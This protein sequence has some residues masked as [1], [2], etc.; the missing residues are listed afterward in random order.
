MDVNRAEV[1]R[2]LE[3]YKRMFFKDQLN[4]PQ[5]N[6]ILNKRKETL[7]LENIDLTNL[8][9]EI[10]EEFFE[11]MNFLKNEVDEEYNL[12]DKN[13]TL[14]YFKTL[15]LV[16]E[17]IDL[18]IEKLKKGFE[19]E[20]EKDHLEAPLEDIKEQEKEI[21]LLETVDSI[22]PLEFTE[23]EQ[24]IH[25]EINKFFDFNNEIK[26]EIKEVEEV[27]D[28]EKYLGIFEED[29]QK[30]IENDEFFYEYINT[31]SKEFKVESLKL[32]FFNGCLICL[33]KIKEKI[34]LAENIKYPD[35][36]SFL[37]LFY[38][39][40]KELIN[41][42][43][44]VLIKEGICEDNFPKD[45]LFEKIF[46]LQCLETLSKQIKKISIMEK[47]NIA[48]AEIIKSIE[49][50][51]NV[52]IN[53]SNKEHF[54]TLAIDVLTEEIDKILGDFNF[55]YAKKDSKKYKVKLFI[56][57]I[58]FINKCA[59]A[60]FD[61]YT[62]DFGRSL[63]ILLEKNDKI[64]KN[65]SEIKNFDDEEVKGFIKDYPY[66]EDL[67]V[68]FAERKENC[69]VKTDCLNRALDIID[70]CGA[71]NSNILEAL[72]LVKLDVYDEY[73]SR[74]PKELEENIKAALAEYLIRKFKFE[75][76]YDVIF[77]LEV[78]NFGKLLSKI[79][80]DSVD[81]D[82][83]REVFKS[84]L[85]KLKD[86]EL[87]SEN[88]K[89]TIEEN[90]FKYNISNWE[91]FKVEYAVFGFAFEENIFE[92]LD[93]NEKSVLLDYC[94]KSIKDLNLSEEKTRKSLLELQ[95]KNITS[96]KEF[97]R[98]EYEIFTTV[99]P[100]T[101]EEEKEFAL[102]NKIREFYNANLTKLIKLDIVIRE[103]GKELKVP[104]FY[105]DLGFN[106]EEIFMIYSEKSNFSNKQEQFLL[107]G[108]KIYSSYENNYV[109]IEDIAKFELKNYSK[110]IKGERI[111]F[112][113]IFVVL[114]NDKEFKLCS[115]LSVGKEELFN[116]LNN[117]IESYYKIYNIEMEENEEEAEIDSIVSFMDETASLENKELVKELKLNLA[118]NK[119]YELMSDLLNSGELDIKDINLE[120]SKIIN[121]ELTKKVF[122]KD[123]SEGYS[124]KLSAAT[125]SYV[126]EIDKA[127]EI[128]F[129]YDNSRFGSA[130]EGFIISDRGIYCKNRMD[131]PWFLEL[132]YIDTIKVKDNNKILIN[133][134]VIEFSNLKT[135]EQIYEMR[136][137]LELIVV[138]NNLTNNF[139]EEEKSPLINY[140]TEALNSIKSENLRKFLYMHNEGKIAE[141]KFNTAVNS[142]A[143]LE[144]NEKPLI[145]FDNSSFAFGV[146]GFLIT[147]KNIY[148]KESMSKPI[149]FNLGA[150]YKLKYNNSNF[151]INSVIL[152]LSGLEDEDKEELREMLS[153]L[154]DYIK[155]N[156]IKK[157]INE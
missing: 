16:E 97:R 55:D 116:M 69:F 79:E 103:N 83:R 1:K 59:I 112:E 121:N 47:N 156:F 134:R 54:K 91:A 155:E 147:T 74:I 87:K 67:Y 33:K 28:I 23:D 124:E 98:I 113:G 126:L 51:A 135:K 13:K 84:E 65:H 17:D 32:L 40:Y 66:N 2:Y 8:E 50:S 131:N 130:K 148:S 144:E 4:N 80:I 44:G 34:S 18:L 78:K 94:M 86:E 27:I 60:N 128:F 153:N 95:N 143:D 96:K 110:V 136:D 75:E 35:K 3:S 24:E 157:Q 150:V 93:L 105:Y 104:E 154:V 82:L 72:D 73:L 92:E 15:N 21:E 6:A 146:S 118:E 19:E 38:D 77:N 120:A 101:E 70:N 100:L 71:K 46:G 151:Y 89:N 63:N 39:S 7:G 145:L 57:A 64:E 133:N 138:V 5:S 12:L 29:N 142:Y 11:A 122:F 132:K 62:E 88:L 76:N 107:E 115:N 119:F 152:K 85:L 58:K 22:E 127:E 106:E 102:L 139:V 10:R 25:D 30:L 48:K 42:S 45:K 20:A 26:E 140:V 52:Y 114:K 43:Y 137:L 149:K 9:K 41:Y 37:K 56:E 125:T 31:N 68:I 129:V 81:L 90:K 99:K 111:F 36:D 141:K 61:I 14:E 49:K 117:Y 53:N 108:N 109:L 123:V